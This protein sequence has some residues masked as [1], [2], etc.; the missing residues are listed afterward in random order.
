MLRGNIKTFTFS[1]N[2]TSKKITTEFVRRIFDKANGTV[3]GTVQNIGNLWSPP[4]PNDGD[5]IVLYDKFADRWFISQFEMES[6][7]RGIIHIAISTSPDP[8][9]NYYTYSFNFNFYFPDYPKFSIWSDGYYMTTNN[10]IEGPVKEVV[11]FERGAMLQGD[12][13]ARLMVQDVDLGTAQGFPQSAVFPS[14]PSAD[15]LLPPGGTPCPLVFRR[16]NNLGA[17]NDEIVLIPLHTDWNNQSFT[18]SAEIALPLSSFDSSFNRNDVI[19]GYTSQRLDIVGP[20]MMFRSQWRKWTGYNTL[21][22]SFAVK[23]SDG[24]YATKWLELRQD[25]NTSNWSVYQ[26]GIYAPDNLSRFMSSIAMDDKGNIGMM[27][28]TTGRLSST[29]VV[30]PGLRYTG[31]KKTDPLNQMTYQEKVAVDGFYTAFCNGRIGDYSQTTL[32][33]ENGIDFW[34]T[35]HYYYNGDTR[36]RIFSFR[37]DDG[38][39]TDVFEDQ[40]TDL[41][42]YQQSGNLLVEFNPENNLINKSLS[43]DLF[44]SVGKL[45][46]HQDCLVK[47]ELIKRQFDLTSLSSGMYL[48]RIGNFDFQKVVRVLIK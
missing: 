1:V 2:S 25:Q 30:A 33:P 44:D 35:G 17:T 6:F 14:T 43:I 13:N 48:V 11:V 40:I 42:V 20:A 22:T 32:D 34:N 26:D 3:L 23:M 8:T 38:F 19:Q 9:G 15:G 7:S 21:L 4:T 39:S 5:P 36:S 41:V 18:A 16:D 12:P 46:N 10:N 45:L 29:N 47:N 28:I 24:V 31:R 27:Y 37:I